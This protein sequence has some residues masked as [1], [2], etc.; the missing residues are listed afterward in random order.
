MRLGTGWG[1]GDLWVAS[2][3][4]SQSSCVLACGGKKRMVA[5]NRH[6]HYRRGNYLPP[7]HSLSILSEVQP[8]VSDGDVVADYSCSARSDYAGSFVFATDL[9]S[10]NPH[11]N[12]SPL[13]S[14]VC[15]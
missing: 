2:M 4:Y 5:G 12:G 8:A 14:A 9:N 15:A 13:R 10:L 3:V 7:G 11:A 6:H 1:H